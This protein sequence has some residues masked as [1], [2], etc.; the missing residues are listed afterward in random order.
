MIA[1]N[2]MLVM[3]LRDS[4]ADIADKGQAVIGIVVII[5]VVI[6]ATAAPVGTQV[7]IRVIK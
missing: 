2:V 1:G 6:V 3:R 5:V 7:I 4:G